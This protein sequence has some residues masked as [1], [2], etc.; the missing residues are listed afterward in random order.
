VRT[1]ASCTGCTPG[2]LNVHFNP[3]TGG[4]NYFSTAQMNVLTTPGPGDFS[5]LGR[6]FF[7]LGRYNVLN[8]S[9]GKITRI[10]ERHLFELRIEMQNALNSKHYGLPGSIR[11]NS[12]FF[13]IAD[14]G[15][16]GAGS[17]PRTMQLSAKY[18]F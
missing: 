3:D 5:N 7:R 17:N 12:G 11:T 18:S 6:N 4:L 15:I 8:L 1:P 13:G 16:A 14:A 10:T 2:M 9:L